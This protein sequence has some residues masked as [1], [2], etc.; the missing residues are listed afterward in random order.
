MGVTPITR[1][2]KASPIGKLFLYNL[3][4]ER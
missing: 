2:L 1:T 3:F 4:E